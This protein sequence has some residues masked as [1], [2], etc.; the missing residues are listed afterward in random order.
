MT[1]IKKSSTRGSSEAIDLKLVLRPSKTQSKF[2]TK[3]DLRCTD[4]PLILATFRGY[5]SSVKKLMKEGHNLETRNYDGDTALILA[6]KQCHINIM[7][8]LL[9]KGKVNIDATDNYG[10]TAL[11][12]AVQIGD[13]KATA[14]LLKEKASITRMDSAGDTAISIAVKKGYKKIEK[15]LKEVYYG[16]N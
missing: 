12:L 1:K 5:I 14:L 8:L 4:D 7:K 2:F 11:M 6:M 15:L 16:R 13:V 10:R 9:R 3:D